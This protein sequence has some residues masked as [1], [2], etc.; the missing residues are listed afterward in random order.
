MLEKFPGGYPMT[1]RTSALLFLLTVSAVA[2]T[3]PNLGRA[4]QP[5]VGHVAPLKE[6]PPDQRFE[7][8]SGDREV[9][10]ERTP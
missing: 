6:F 1:R 2:V 8:V 7:T 9:A 3:F 10:P 4:Q 5:V